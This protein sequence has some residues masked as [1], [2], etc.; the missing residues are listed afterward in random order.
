MKKMYLII[1]MLTLILAGCDTFLEVQPTEDL[2][3][4]QVA[5]I[6]TETAMAETPPPTETMVPSV[7][8][9]TEEPSETPT[10]SSSITATATQTVPPSDPAVL[11]GNPVWT[12]D[13]NGTSSPWD[14][15]SEQAIFETSNG[16]LN[17]TA[18]ANRN[19][20][21][22][23]VSSPKLKDAYVEITAV[24]NTCTGFDRFVFAVR[25]SST[26]D[27]FYFLDL[28]C[29]GRWGFFRMAPDVE[30]NEIRAYQEIDVTFNSWTEPHRVGIWME[31]SN[32][33]FYIDGEEIGVASD[34]TLLGEGYTGFMIAFSETPGYTVRVDQLQYWNIP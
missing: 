5:S 28:T 25:A 29:D 13:F 26:G 2:L 15:E 12:Y 10:E 34:D 24:M 14:Y 7:T 17:I 30:I 11:L 23:W 4:T 27:Q 20:H 1:L 9:T 33:R 18:Q 3:A 8:A 31:G 6:L 19:W 16:Y 21:S 22:W 32:F